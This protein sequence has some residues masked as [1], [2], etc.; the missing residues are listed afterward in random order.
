VLSNAVNLLALQA[1]TKSK[2]ECMWGV[3]AAL[4]GLS[5]GCLK[6]LGARR[7]SSVDVSH[8]SS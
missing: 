4:H 8:L 6:G 7:Q 2:A 1:I 5:D 3:D